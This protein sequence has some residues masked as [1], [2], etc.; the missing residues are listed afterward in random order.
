[1]SDRAADESDPDLPTLEDLAAIVALVE[2]HGALYLRYSRGPA[3]DAK[4]GHSRD[5]ESGL[6]LPGLS[7]TVVSPEPWWTRPVEEWVARR[8]C[9][10]DELDDEERYPWLLTGELVGFGPDHEH[11]YRQ[12]ILLPESARGLSMRL[13][14]STSNASTSARTP[15]PDLG[16]R[17]SPSVGDLA[18]W[19]Q[20]S[21]VAGRGTSGT[22][23]C[24]VFPG[25]A[26]YSDGF[27]SGCPVALGMRAPRGDAAAVLVGGI[28]LAAGLNHFA[29]LR[30]G[31]P[32]DSRRV[33]QSACGPRW[34]NRRPRALVAAGERAGGGAIGVI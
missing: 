8:I 12:S 26:V 5:Y 30:R 2:R 17:G 27:A 10:Y 21:I 33:D 9:K 15:A 14:P 11:C 29:L 16:Q 32:R 31:R 25:S 20:V 18:P 1:V 3:S 13:D 23:G 6:E 22:N 34:S 28:L 4:D 24:G 7:V 19:T